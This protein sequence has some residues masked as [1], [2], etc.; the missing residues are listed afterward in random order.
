MKII[1]ARVKDILK[2]ITAPQCPKTKVSAFT[3]GPIT[4]AAHIHLVVFSLK[5][6]YVI[7]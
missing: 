4:H 2:Q 5:F 1:W 6:V 7:A 3:R